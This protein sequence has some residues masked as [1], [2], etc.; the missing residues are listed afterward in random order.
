MWWVISRSAGCC[1][2]GSPSICIGTDSERRI[3]TWR[4]WPTLQNVIYQLRNFD[5]IIVYLPVGFTQ[6]DLHLG[7]VETGEDTED[8]QL[9]V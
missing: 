2:Q 1:S 5:F 7:D 3:L 8:L 4:A 9:A 6:T